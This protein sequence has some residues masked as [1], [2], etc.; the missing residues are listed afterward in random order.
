[1]YT[2]THI[3]M[4]DIHTLI[5]SANLHDGKTADLVA[6]HVTHLNDLCHTYESFREHACMSMLICSHFTLCIVYNTVQVQ[7]EEVRRR[8]LCGRYWQKGG[9]G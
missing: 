1:M 3:H 7:M 5:T 6:S 4:Y 8:R 9:S 2:H